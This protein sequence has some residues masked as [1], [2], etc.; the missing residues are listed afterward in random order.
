MLRGDLARVGADA[1]LAA[2]F[3]QIE[4]SRLTAQL[5]TFPARGMIAAWLTAGV[6]DTCQG[7]QGRITTVA[8][9]HSVDR[10]QLVEQIAS[11]SPDLVRKMITSLFRG[12]CG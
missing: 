1:D 3:D 5:G 9:P 6:L 10:A 2:A 11:T 8:A 7:T 4:H 12:F